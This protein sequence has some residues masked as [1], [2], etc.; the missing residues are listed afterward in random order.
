MSFIAG[1]NYLLEV[2]ADDYWYLSE[3]LIL[4]QVTTFMNINRDILL[5]PVTVGSSIDLNIR[6]DVNSSFLA[7]ES[8]AEL[9]RLIRQLKDN[10]TVRIEIQ[11]HCDDLEALQQ[12]GIALERANAVGK[13]LVENGFSNFELKS[14][15]NTTP[16]SS[17]ETEEGRAQNRRVGIV[18]LSR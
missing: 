6:F 11:G 8:V 18:V 2:V 10:Q 3:N 12:P 15:G 5:K 9:N 13:Y 4:Q 1:D 16:I 17:N 14:M 7:P